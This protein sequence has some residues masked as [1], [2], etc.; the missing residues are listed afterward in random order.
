M[1][2]AGRSLRRQGDRSLRAKGSAI[3]RR[4]HMGDGDFV[5]SGMGQMLWRGNS[6]TFMNVTALLYEYIV[7]AYKLQLKK[8]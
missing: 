2:E 7:K 1:W 3:I 6:V 8:S 5:H 4:E